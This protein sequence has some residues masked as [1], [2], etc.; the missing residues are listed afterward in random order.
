MTDLS[1]SQTTHAAKPVCGCMHQTPFA[2]RIRS[3]VGICTMAV[4][5]ISESDQV[6]SITA[7][8]RADLCTIA[9]PPL[10]DPA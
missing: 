7:A 1:S 2:D 3:E 10:A 8:G 5:V 6:N 4:G 9:R